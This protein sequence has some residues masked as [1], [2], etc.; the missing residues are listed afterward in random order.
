MNNPRKSTSVEDSA[1]LVLVLPEAFC[2]QCW[3]I[4]VHSLVLLFRRIKLLANS[5]LCFCCLVPSF[6]LTSRMPWEWINWSSGMILQ[7]RML[8]LLGNLSVFIRP[9]LDGGALLE[10]RAGHWLVWFTSSPAFC[11]YCSADFFAG[12]VSAYRWWW[13]LDSSN[14]LSRK[15]QPYSMIEK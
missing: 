14:V 9:E 15:K 8:L 2:C 12:T 4:Y 3:D 1:C 5:R 11:I 7:L 13:A 6:S 10:F